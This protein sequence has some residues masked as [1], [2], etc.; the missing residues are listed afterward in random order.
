MQFDKLWSKNIFFQSPSQDTL[1]NISYPPQLA[2]VV[3][4]CWIWFLFS[5]SV[6]FLKDATFNVLNDKDFLSL[7][8]NQRLQI[9]FFVLI[10]LRCLVSKAFKVWRFCHH[11]CEDECDGEDHEE[12]AEASESESNQESK[13]FQ[14]CHFILKYLSLN[15]SELKCFWR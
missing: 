15:Q 3:S 1:P 12:H 6:I 5:S 9:F 11:L 10:I 14:C 7:I 13:R 8:V 4:K 2:C